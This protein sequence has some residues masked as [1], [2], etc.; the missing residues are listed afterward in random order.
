MKGI[1]I[2]MCRESSGGRCVFTTG[3]W[4]ISYPAD[5]SQECSSGS[6]ELDISIFSRTLR[7]ISWW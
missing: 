2:A 3:L 5:L 7:P 6:S 1:I 4:W